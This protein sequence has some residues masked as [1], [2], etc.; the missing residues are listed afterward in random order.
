MSGSSAGAKA[1][2]TIVIAEDEEPIRELLR[3]QL[4]ELGHR[5]V[6]FAD[7]QSALDYIQESPPDLVILD[8]MMPRKNGWDVARALRNSPHTS[9]VKILMLTAVGSEL[10]HAV[11]SS[12]GADASIDK[13][14]ELGELLDTIAELLAG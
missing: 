1:T 7:G 13:P 11:R 12:F 14:F 4:E 2:A 3:Q 5:V 8:V 10:N 9:A 6:E